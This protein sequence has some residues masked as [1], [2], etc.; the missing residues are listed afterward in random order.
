MAEAKHIKAKTILL[1]S[2]RVRSGLD[3]NHSALERESIYNLG[4]PGVNMYQSLAYFK[5]TL[6]YQKN[7]QQV[8]IGIDFFMSN[9][10]LDNLDS[11]DETRLGK[12]IGIKE[13][14]NNSLSLDTLESSIIT[15]RANVNKQAQ[16]KNLESTPHRFK[17]WLTNFLSFDGFYKNYGLS[18]KQLYSFQ[19]VINLCEQNNIDVKVFISPTHATQ[20]EAIAAAGLWSTFEQWKR[21]I[22][23]ITPVWDFSGYNRITTEKIDDRMNNYIDSSHY[24]HYTGNLVLNRLFFDRLETVPADFGVFITQENLESHLEKIRQDRTKW[25]QNNPEEVQLVKNIKTQ[26]ARKK[27]K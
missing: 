26:I 3:I 25:Q 7:I 13:L 14:I 1:G 11:F 10:Y 12:K 18:E 4:L 15:V 2:S 8:I 20:Y 16:S 9:H 6:A 5:H 27:F 24:S 17:R 22:T 23:K 21:E 19:E